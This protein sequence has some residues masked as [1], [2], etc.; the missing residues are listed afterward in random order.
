M[1]IVTTEH[2]TLHGD[3]VG[4]HL[5]VR[6]ARAFSWRPAASLRLA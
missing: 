6:R 1:T 5:G 4:D 2:F 3:A